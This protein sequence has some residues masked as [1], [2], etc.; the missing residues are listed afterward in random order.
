MD[1]TVRTLIRRLGAEGRNSGSILQE[2]RVAL[3]KCLE[4]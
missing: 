1:I 2:V 3:A 4:R